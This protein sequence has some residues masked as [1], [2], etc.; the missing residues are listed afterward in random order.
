MSTAEAKR[1]SNRGFTARTVETLQ[2]PGRHK[3]P[4]TRGLYLQV[5]PKGTKSWL[6][7]FMLDGRAREMGLGPFPEVTLAEARELALQ[8]RRLTVKGLDPITQREADRRALR[9]QRD[10]DAITFEAAARRYIADHRDGWRNPKHADQWASTLKAYAYPALGSRDVRSIETPDVEAVLR[11][12]WLDKHETASRLRGRIERVLDW[13][14]T[15]GYRSGLNPA[16]WKA[17]LDHLLPRRQKRQVRHHPS[18]PWSEVPAFL[19]R[20]RQCEGMGAAALEFAILTAARSGETRGA[21]WEEIDLQ[22]AVWTIPGERMKAGRT[23]RVPLSEPA[24][25]LLRRLP[26]LAGSP[27]LFW[28]PRGGMLSDMALLSVTRRLEAKCVPH[29]FRS[30]FR[31]WAAEQTAYPREVVEQALAHVNADKVEAAYLRSDLFE[32]R[33]ELM[34]DWA[35]HC[36]SKKKKPKASSARLVV[37]GEANEA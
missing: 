31:D 22:T 28:A 9:A 1:R 33:R 36:E 35:T 37:V 4:A 13:C 32:R 25:A 30:S 10:E 16:R 23:H 26:R 2:K 15:M 29:G 17:N 11:P 8:A 3:D 18:M 19:G 21:R 5:T 34:A 7:R 27:Y 12:L 20:L 24:V 6:F 14:A